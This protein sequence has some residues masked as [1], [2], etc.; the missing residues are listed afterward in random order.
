MVR[1]DRLSPPL[2]V[3]KAFAET[4]TLN[5]LLNVATIDRPP[6]VSTNFGPQGQPPPRLKR[7]TRARVT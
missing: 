1:R 6:T 4:I 3:S 2:T 7:A 5:I